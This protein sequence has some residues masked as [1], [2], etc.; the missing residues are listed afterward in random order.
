MP[1]LTIA[2]PSFA[3][4]TLNVMFFVT[5]PDGFVF[6]GRTGGILRLGNLRRSLRA[7]VRYTHLIRVYP[8][9][10]RKTVGTL[11]EREEGLT[12]CEFTNSGTLPKR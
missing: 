8:H 4:E 10:L 2:L 11:I 5:G 3:V 9:L 7:A 12:A 6:R 1:D